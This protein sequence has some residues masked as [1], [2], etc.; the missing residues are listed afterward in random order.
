MVSS[1]SRLSERETFLRKRVQQLLPL[2]EKEYPHSQ[3]SLH[4]KT[5]FQL[6]VAV[7]LSAQCTDAR[8]NQV[9]PALFEH[10]P[11]AK[12][13]SQA[14]PEALERLIY[15]TG[16]YRAKTRALL[17]LAQALHTHHQGEPPRTLEALTE[18]KGVGRKTANVV[19]GVAYGIPGIVVDTHVQ[20]L[21]RRLGLTAHVQPE[22]IEQDLMRVVPQPDWTRWSHWMV[23]HGRKYCMARKPACSLCPLR[24]ECP[25]RLV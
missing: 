23:D 19:L 7:V 5:P 20:R 14:S 25:Q 15:S 21:S 4:F 9:T 2:L 18:L 1:K 24:K 10:Y 8:V 11:N 17:A 3:C 12:A 16:F 22:K 13:L 6:L